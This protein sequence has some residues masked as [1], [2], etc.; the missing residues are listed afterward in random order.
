MIAPMLSNILNKA[1]ASNSNYDFTYLFKFSGKIDIYNFGSE[2]LLFKHRLISRKLY[3]L[4]IQT[5]FTIMKLF[6][7]INLASS[8]T[9][10]QLMLSSAVKSKKYFVSVFFD[11]CKTFETICDYILM[12]KKT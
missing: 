9:K 12:K 8:R 6:M 11:L 5:S 10:Q 2:I 3:T 1:L 4:V 7:K